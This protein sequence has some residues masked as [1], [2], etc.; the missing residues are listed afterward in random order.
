MNILYLWTKTLGDKSSFLNKQFNTRRILVIL[1]TV[2]ESKFC[3]IISQN[4]RT[5]SC[6]LERLLHLNEYYL[7][8]PR[9]KYF[10]PLMILLKN[11]MKDCVT[12]LIL[13]NNKLSGT[14]SDVEPKNI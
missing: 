11:I 14:Q 2:H 1:Y 9:L 12:C 8:L 7:N 3:F 6:F 5:S 4:M 10:L 13:I